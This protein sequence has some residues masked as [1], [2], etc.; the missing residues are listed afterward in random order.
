M[1]VCI[2]RNEN[3]IYVLSIHVCTWFGRIRRSTKTETNLNLFFLSL[4]FVFRRDEWNR[5]IWIELWKFCRTLIVLIY[6]ICVFFWM[7]KFGRRDWRL[8]AIACSKH[9]DMMAYDE[10]RERSQIKL[11]IRIRWCEYMCAISCFWFTSGSHLLIPGICENE[12]CCLKFRPNI[13]VFFVIFG[14]R[15]HLKK[16]M[17]S[18]LKCVSSTSSRPFDIF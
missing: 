2:Q 10:N 8:V 6:R 4:F 14:K 15:F 11:M 5:V 7:K 12:T 17:K 13:R 18:T 3:F 1:C 9:H 16:R